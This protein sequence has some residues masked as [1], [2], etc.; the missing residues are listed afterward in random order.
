MYVY[1]R[2]DVCR[3]ASQQARVRL[4]VYVNAFEQLARITDRTRF[5]ALGNRS[6]ADHFAKRVYSIT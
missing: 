4:H 2:K 3:L 1:I 5:V 6:A